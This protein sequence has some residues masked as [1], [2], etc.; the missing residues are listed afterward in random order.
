[1]LQFLISEREREVDE[2]EDLSGLGGSG[3]GGGGGGG[4]SPSP[5]PSASGGLGGGGASPSATP[6]D[7][8]QQLK[9]DPGFRSIADARARIAEQD[10]QWGQVFDRLASF[11]SVRSATF[12]VTITATTG[13]VKSIA[14]ATARREGG[15]VL[16]IVLD[17][18]PPR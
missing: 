13:K 17:P 5:S 15:R 7:N 10:P 2:S 9:L 14:R 12:R 3:G 8:S 16:W 6:A 4:A 18:D 11:L 1:M